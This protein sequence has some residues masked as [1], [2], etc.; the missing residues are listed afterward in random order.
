[1]Q[2]IQEPVES[3]GV[4]DGKVKWLKAGSVAALALL[5]IVMF[6]NRVVVR[7]AAENPELLT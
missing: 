2:P 4:S 3:K 5:L 6:G 1:M 7:N